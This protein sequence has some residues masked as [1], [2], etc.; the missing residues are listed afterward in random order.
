MK[1]CSICDTEKPYDL[2]RKRKSAKDGHTAACKDCLSSIPKIK[3]LS[4]IEIMSRNI[5][6]KN[7]ELQLKN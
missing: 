7:F 3:K 4:L 2:F 5:W 6:D 1:K